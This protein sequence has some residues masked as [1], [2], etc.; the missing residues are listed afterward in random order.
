MEE[1]HIVTGTLLGA[2]L[3]QYVVLSQAR[4]FI[5]GF[6]KANDPK[7]SGLK[8]AGPPPGSDIVIPQGGRPRTGVKPMIGFRADDKELP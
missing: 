6:G 2:Y 7:I 4:N 8:R 3:P 5:A 1:H